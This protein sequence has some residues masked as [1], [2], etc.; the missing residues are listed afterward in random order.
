MVTATPIDKKNRGIFNLKSSL[1]FITRSA[2]IAAVYFAFSAAVQPVAFGPVQF[3][4][5]EALALLPVLMPESIAGLAI[6]CFFTNFFFSPF[7]LYDMLFGTLA[8]LLGAVLTRLLR[9]NVVLAALPPIILNALLVPLIWVCDGSGAIYYIA[10]LEILASQTI[11]CGAIGIPFTLLLKKTL[12]SAKLIDKDRKDYR[13][14]PAYIR[15][16]PQRRSKE[17]DVGED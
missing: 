14:T 2:I 12:I 3:R 17:D 7:G 1:K 5:S 10:M 11:I 9:K 16:Q 4:L 13:N 8:T 15:L 6:G